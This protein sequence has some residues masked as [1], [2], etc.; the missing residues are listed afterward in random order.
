MTIS[1]HTSKVTIR[2]VALK[3]G[4]SPGTVSRVLNNLPSVD[5][6]LRSRVM[7][8][9]E[10]LQYVHVP[11]RRGMA[12]GHGLSS[13]GAATSI[14][15]AIRNMET[16]AP[17]NAYYSHVLHG[18][19]AECA[20]HDINLV[21][22]V[23]DD[24][25]EA[26]PEITAV[27]QRGQAAG[28]L[29]TGLGSRQ[30]VEGLLSLDLPMVLINNHF[31]DLPVG[32]VTSDFGQGIVLAMQ[33]LYELGH[34]DIAFINGP[35]SEYSVQRRDDGFYKALRLLG[36]PYQS[37]LVLETT[38]TVAG[39]EAA[40]QRLLQSGARFSAVCCANDG[41]A[42]GVMRALREFGLRI[43]QDVSVVGFDDVDAAALTTPALTTIHSDIAAVGSLAM[44]Q[45]LE[46][47]NH[48]ERPPHQILLHVQ[49]VTRQST[50]ATGA[51]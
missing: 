20:R 48:P 4:V 1:N 13:D 11:R 35:R 38:M 33:H 23:F 17:R 10:M 16:P 27:V 51:A 18:A 2:D 43:P 25:P 31:P 41:I 3:A 50:A 47:I 12:P 32:S 6:T 21:Y 34:R 40:T 44:A 45:L 49:L 7:V 8:A 29:L 37:E 26:L 46:H 28:L 5:D 30:L 9:V 24:S 15:M 36:L 39:G 42:F 22:T 19:E 14:V